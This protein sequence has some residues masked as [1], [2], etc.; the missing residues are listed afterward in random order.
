MTWVQLGSGLIVILGVLYWGFAKK[1][2]DMF[3][4]ALKQ[5]RNFNFDKQL[6]I[7]NYYRLNGQSDMQKLILEWSNLLIDNEGTKKMGPF[8]LLALQGQTIGYASEKTIK[9]VGNFMQFLYVQNTQDNSEQ[10]QSENKKGDEDTY[11]FIAFIAVIVS[12][13]KQDFTGQSFDP[14]DLIRI[15]INDLNKIS[16]ARY[17][18]E[19][20]KIKE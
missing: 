3:R 14:I 9:T 19:I 15:K 12:L 11:T 4:D 5:N 1:I 16:E 10:N 17:R 13:L 18:D 20:R 8:G 7:D 2:P 6:Q